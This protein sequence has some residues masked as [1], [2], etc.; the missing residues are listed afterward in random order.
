MFAPSFTS[1]LINSLLL[2]LRVS[3]IRLVRLPT[4]TRLFIMVLPW[5]LIFRL[6]I[7]VVPPPAKVIP[8]NVVTSPVL[9]V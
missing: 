4:E 3:V 6:F 5:L 9:S 2:A 8:P 1:D 7:Q